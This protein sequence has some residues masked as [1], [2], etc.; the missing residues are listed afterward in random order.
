MQ[1]PG[2]FTPEQL[3]LWYSSGWL[4]PNLVML[5]TEYDKVAFQLSEWQAMAET[6][7]IKTE[8]MFH[9]WHAPLSTAADLLSLP[10]ASHREDPKPA[11]IPSAPVSSVAQSDVG[12]PARSVFA[13]ITSAGAQRSSSI[14]LLSGSR[15]KPRANEVDPN[16]GFNPM[17]PA[18]MQARPG[19]MEGSSAGSPA[20]INASTSDSALGGVGMGSGGIFVRGSGAIGSTVSSGQ[21]GFSN[22]HPSPG[23]FGA[24]DPMHTFGGGGLG[25]GNGFGGFED[26][27]VQRLASGTYTRTYDHSAVTSPHQPWGQSIGA[28]TP[29]SYGRP[30]ATFGGR[31]S[32]SPIP[33]V[34][35]L[36]GDAYDVIG[37]NRRVDSLGM[38]QQQTA[39][40]QPQPPQ[41]YVSPFPLPHE[42][43]PRRSQ[44]MFGPYPGNA[45]QVI[46][47]P[48]QL[49]QPPVPLSLPPV[50]K[51]DEEVM[52]RPKGPLDQ[53]LI[54]TILPNSPVM[55][56][57]EGSLI[58]KPKPHPQLQ[59]QTQTQ[60]PGQENPALA[61][62]P[63][64]APA[65]KATPPTS[66]A[67]DDSNQPFTQVKSKKHHHPQS[68]LAQ[69]AAPVP[70]QPAPAKVEHSS[71]IPLATLTVPL[72]SLILPAVPSSSAVSAPKTAWATPTTKDE[73]TKS[74]TLKEIQEAEEKRAKE[75]GARQK[76]A[77]SG[78][79]PAPVNTV[80]SSKSDEVEIFTW[81]LPTSK[82]GS[83]LNAAPAPTSTG[84]GKDASSTGPVWVIGPKGG[85]STGATSAKK[86]MKEIQEE[87]ERKKRREKEAS[88]ATAAKK[89]TESNKSSA[90]T[91][92]TT[93]GSA[94]STV[95]AGGK[96]TSAPAPR[97]TGLAALPPKPTAAAAAANRPS[98]VTA[99]LFSTAASVGVP[100]R[101]V[102]PSPASK[103]I[104]APVKP[105]EEPQEPPVSA[106]TMRWMKESLQKGLKPGSTGKC[107]L[108][109][110][111]LSSSSPHSTVD[112]I[113]G[114]VLLIQEEEFIADIIY[115]SSETMDGRR[116]AA[117]L[118]S[119]RKADAANISS[120]SGASGRAGS[121]SGSITEV[122]K[123]QPR[124]TALDLGYK[125]V[126]KKAKSG[127]A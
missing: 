114:M 43:Q 3:K 20:S 6:R 34:G 1:N 51:N 57:P 124:Q 35:A 109:L 80:T 63:A 2:P 104:V 96:V 10:V 81:G 123:A 125:V 74:L 91:P 52:N 53:E 33:G 47:E 116:W 103:P 14:S 115:Q 11:S 31:R 105:V 86:T 77:I 118:L 45:T 84:G 127:R 22:Y 5:R 55:P 61:P 23:R 83:R 100:T 46:G 73:A 50:V 8:E 30:A 87:E 120:T 82:A 21:A 122:L 93:S 110:C 16:S 65:P 19:T 17:S 113:V 13:A 62:V 70:V 18:R 111:A 25:F 71:N 68:Q 37:S 89:V 36:G 97:P 29:A 60:P 66:I 95:G 58:Q 69:V 106:E 48:V 42:Q 40:P 38:G 121:T 49:T 72:A 39:Q 59:P 119:K 4:R 92:L 12:S 54:P 101:K 88:V 107:L 90:P 15:G 108:L 24:A 79:L 32:E 76:V 126:K 112:V 99:P 28:G 41:H 9:I 117:D 56:I 98:T 27:V 85:I 102:T 26:P 67:I 7:G 75:E 94:W 64:L 44:G 78:T